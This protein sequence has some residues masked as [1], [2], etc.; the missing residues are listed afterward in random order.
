MSD[1]SAFLVL[2]HY[3]TKPEHTNA[4]LELL[5]DLAAASRREPENL[6]YEY[7]QQAGAAGEILI[8]E[9][10]TSSAGF[11]AHRGSEHFQRIGVGQ[12]IPLLE[13]REVEMYETSIAVS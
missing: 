12:I 6:S 3:T 5:D 1:E 2:A 10:Y 7:Y 13:N 4:V 8:V 9:K 11:D